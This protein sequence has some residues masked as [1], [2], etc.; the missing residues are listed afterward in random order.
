MEELLWNI[1]NELFEGDTINV[2]QSE[3]GTPMNDLPQNQVNIVYTVLSKDFHYETINGQRIKHSQEI[4]EVDAS[5]IHTHDCITLARLT[6]S[7][8]YLLFSWNEGADAIL[9]AILQDLVPKAKEAIQNSLHHQFKTSISSAIEARV[10]EY[11]DRIKQ[12]DEEAG[13]MERQILNLRRQIHTDSQALEALDGTK[14]Q[15]KQ[16]AVKEF[17]SLRHLIPNYYASYR[18]D[19]GKLI[20]KTHE[21]SIPYDGCT[22]DIG[23]FEVKITLATGDLEIA[24]LTHEVD[25]YEHPHISGGRP[26]LGNIGKGVI[27][28]L[29]EFELFGA[30]QMIHS[31]LHSYNEDSPYHKIEHWDPGYENEEDSHFQNCR[32]NNSGYE[33]VE[34]GGEGGECPFYDEAFEVCVERSSLD[35]CVNCEYQCRLG[36]ERIQRHQ[37][38]Q[39]HQTE[40]QAA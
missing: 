1:I 33:C 34:C 13:D 38:N 6:G 19:D 11:R 40:V 22:Y 20:A 26:C 37:S 10:Q 15:W 5:T 12:N 24:N 32:D 14:G 7:I 28:M 39:Q 31:F 29:A 8:I 25:G 27:R 4:F 36:R 23:V 16:K 17:E 2:V 9:E 3:D 21:V 30:L 35:D 18:I